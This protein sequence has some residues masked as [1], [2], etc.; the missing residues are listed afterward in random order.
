MSS[1][2][3]EYVSHSLY[4][5]F[6]LYVCTLFPPRPGACLTADSL[7]LSLIVPNHGIVDITDWKRRPTQSTE[8]RPAL[9]SPDRRV[10][11]LQHSYTATLAPKTDARTHRQPQAPPAAT[12]HRFLRLVPVAIVDDRH[13][14]RQRHGQSTGDSDLAVAVTNNPVDL[15]FPQSR[16]G[17]H[18]SLV[19]DDVDLTRSSRQYL[20][21]HRQRGVALTC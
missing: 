12:I 9:P 21:A 2:C 5:F 6:A 13:P 11:S 16:D 18:L 10:P 4:F 15:P 17:H 14:G 1:G 19:V 3:P 8:F 7:T 20:Q